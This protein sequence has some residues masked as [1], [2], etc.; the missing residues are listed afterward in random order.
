[1]TWDQLANAQSN[2]RLGAFKQVEYMLKDERK[3]AATKS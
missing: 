2:V 1:V 3:H